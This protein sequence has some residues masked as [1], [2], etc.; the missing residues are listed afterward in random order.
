MVPPNVEF[1]K[2]SADLISIYQS[3]IKRSSIY[4]N[5]IRFQCIPGETAWLN[6]ILLDKTHVNLI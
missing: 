1:A 3:S 2:S 6:L 4:F 5:V